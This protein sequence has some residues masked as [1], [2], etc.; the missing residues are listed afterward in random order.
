MKKNA[1]KIAIIILSII[2]V[3]LAGYIIWDKFISFDNGSINNKD[4]QSNIEENI[5]SVTENKD[6]TSE[7]VKFENY[8][9]S[10]IRDIVITTAVEENG[11]PVEKKHTITDI[12][13]VMEIIKVLDQAEYVNT[14]PEG[15]GFIYPTSIEVNH[16]ED[17]S[18]DIIFMSNG[19]VAIN[20]A[21]GS[22]ETGYAE[23]TLNN[24]NF[25]VEIINKYFS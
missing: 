21:V 23:Y 13:E 15:I 11:N 25:E 10:N 18:V 16:K 20:Y 14:I 12:K 5:E 2:V 7:D 4:S 1:S 6:N 22:A 17:P 9:L 3:V 8:N 24:K 19:N